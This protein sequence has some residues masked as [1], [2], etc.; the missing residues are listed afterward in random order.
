MLNEQPR[1]T[2]QLLQRGHH[3]GETESLSPVSAAEA[4]G[5]SPSAQDTQP[6]KA[7]Q[8]APNQGLPAEPGPGVGGGGLRSP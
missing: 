8:E 2:A 5:F 4:L 6:G 1:P 3:S 7:K